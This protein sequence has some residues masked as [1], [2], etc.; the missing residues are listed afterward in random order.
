MLRQNGLCEI[1]WHAPT[2]HSNEPDHSATSS[3]EHMPSASM[4]PTEKTSRR[5]AVERKRLTVSLPLDLLERSR[6]T[7]YWTKGL[8]LAQLLE[9]A[10]T[11]SLDQL[12]RVH[13]QPF[14]QR[15][16]DLKGGRPPNS[17]RTDTRQ[18]TATHLD[19]VKRS[20]QDDGNIIEDT[21]SWPTSEGTAFLCLDE[22][23]LPG[24]GFAHSLI[25]LSC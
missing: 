18:S 14:P 2:D 24:L 25:R 10:L 22:V 17:D 6:N 1:A 8:T 20:R 16:E 19:G 21:F 23:R 15:L 5:K 4:A 12:E 9:Q 3:S 13:G 11:C 7:V